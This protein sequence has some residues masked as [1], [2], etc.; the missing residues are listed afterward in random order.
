MDHEPVLISTL[1]VG[2][3]AAFIGGF[4]AQRLKLP[5]IVGYIV[6]GIVIGPF[7]PGLMAD[8]AVATELAEIGI[9]LLMFGVGIH[10]S[11]RDLLA[12]KNIAVPG[13]AGQ[14][15]V[16]TPSGPVLGL[17]LRLEPRW[18]ARARPVDLGGQHRRAA[19]RPHRPQGARDA[20]GSDRRRLA[21]RRGPVH[22]RRPRP[23]PDD[24]PVPRRH[25]RCR[26]HEPSAGHRHRPGARQGRALRRADGRRRGPARPAA[27]GHRGSRG[28]ARALHARGAGHR[29]R[30]R[31]PVGRG[32]RRLPGA[33]RVPGRRHRQRIGHEP[34]GR[35]RRAPDARRLRGALLRVGRDAARPV[36]SRVAP[37]RDRGAPRAH[38]RRPSRS[39]RSRWS[40]PSAIPSASA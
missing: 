17:A 33:G 40:R 29:P 20:A 16:A 12:V 18:R 9:I 34:P 5:P 37:A 30:A 7:T 2:L 35:R 19:A 22:G 21:H 32:V 27:P 15:A 10:F 23:A 6:A 1:A 3:V 11:F 14:I 4:I 24:R 39:S 38:R 8:R 13:A 36:V 28:L 26:R 31:L 25:E